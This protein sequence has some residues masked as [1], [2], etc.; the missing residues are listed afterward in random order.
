MRSAP[1]VAAITADMAR[2]APL[3]RAV[4]SLC[5]EAGK[6]IPEY[7]PLAARLQALND[8][9]TPEIPAA[10]GVLREAAADLARCLPSA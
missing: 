2:I 7:H 6:A 4:A 1:E 9:E 8:A 10:A 3:P 5:H